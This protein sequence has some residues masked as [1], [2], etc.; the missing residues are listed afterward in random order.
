MKKMVKG[1]N[2]LEDLKAKIINAK[3]EREALYLEIDNCNSYEIYI[4]LTKKLSKLTEHIDVL[5]NYQDGIKLK[6]RLEL[7][8]L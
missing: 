1:V 7:C 4:M 8:H 3:A 2:H 6:Q 5:Q